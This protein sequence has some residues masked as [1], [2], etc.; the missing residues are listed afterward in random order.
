[1]T[2]TNPI[3]QNLLHYIPLPNNG[4]NVFT[5]TQVVRQDSNQFGVRLDHYL[6]PSDILNFRYSFSDGSQ[7]NP[8]PTSGASVPGFPVGQEQ[9]AQNFVAQETHTFSPAMIGVLRFSYLR[10]KFLFGE[11]TNHTTPAS[12]G[13]EYKPSLTWPP[14]LPSSR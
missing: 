11:H 9:R 3:S 13:F 4:T 6:T 2:P 12:L 14:V 7:F 10:N 5:S 8:I 1:M